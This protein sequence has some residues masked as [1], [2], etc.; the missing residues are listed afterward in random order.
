MVYEYLILYDE[1]VLKESSLYLLNLNK[2]YTNSSINYKLALRPERCP[3][4]VKGN[5]IKI[6]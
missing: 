2:K 3:G 1:F 4:F 5:D 6:N